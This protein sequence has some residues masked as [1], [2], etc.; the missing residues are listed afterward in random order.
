MKPK[1]SP[2]AIGKNS[3]RKGKAWQ[4]AVAKTISYVTAPTQYEL[5]TNGATSNHGG[6]HGEEDILLSPDTQD[7]FPFFVECKNTKKLQIPA[8]WA[9]LCG[10]ITKKKCN[11]AGIIVSRLYGTSKALVTL[12]FMV[13]LE[14][15]FPDLTE[16][17]LNQA[18]AILFQLEAKGRQKE[19]AKARRASKVKVK[20]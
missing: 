1:R 4:H 15:L 3:Q 2:S 17:Q 5:G 12:D 13:F 19:L 14:I 16:G 7:K 11:N 9:E 10:D 8:W 20:A 6:I 18:R